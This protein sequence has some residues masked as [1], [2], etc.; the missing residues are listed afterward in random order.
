M[1]HLAD[2]LSPLYQTTRGLQ[3]FVCLFDIIVHDMSMSIISAVSGWFLS[4][5]IV[6]L[7]KP[8][9]IDSEMLNLSCSRTAL[10]K[11]QF[12]LCVDKFS[13]VG[14]Q[15]QDVQLRS[16][17][18]SSNSSDGQWVQ[19][20]QFLTFGQRRCTNFNT[21]AV[22]SEENW[23]FTGRELSYAWTMTLSNNWKVGCFFRLH[24]VA[25]FLWDLCVSVH[26]LLVWAIMASTQPIWAA[27]PQAIPWELWSGHSSSRIFLP[28]VVSPTLR[29]DWSTNIVNLVLHKLRPFLVTSSYPVQ[30]YSSQF[31]TWCRFWLHA[32][33]LEQWQSTLTTTTRQIEAL[34]GESC[35]FH[36]LSRSP[37]NGASQPTL[38]SHRHWKNI[39]NRTV[40]G[41][42][43]PRG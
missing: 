25:A 8:D 14:V 20:P 24:L 3:L 33:Q 23:S 38:T 28:W 41:E 9:C 43:T 26:L 17:L 2:K 34:N 13:D 37:E 29:W 15:W 42:T 32:R 1:N 30:S 6:R 12:N 27:Q 31:S 18:A 35:L 36:S 39:L 7:T 5:S 21:S 19:T 40:T 4:R 16:S 22:V 10:W 11:Y